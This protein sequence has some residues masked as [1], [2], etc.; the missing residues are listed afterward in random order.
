MSKNMNNEWNELNYTEELEEGPEIL[1][2][3]MTKVRSER[4]VA[5]TRM[6]QLYVGG[7]TIK[8]E[9]YVTSSTKMERSEKDDWSHG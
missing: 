3:H 5:T 6:E 8:R 2:Q 4:K 1:F 7:M 9:W